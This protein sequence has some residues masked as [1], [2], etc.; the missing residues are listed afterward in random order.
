[1]SAP[2]VEEC[3]T[4]MDTSKSAARG[5][6][7]KI[8]RVTKIF[9]QSYLAPLEQHVKSCEALETMI[10]ANI[11]AICTAWVFDGRYDNQVL[12]NVM[13]SRRSLLESQ[14]EAS[15]ASSGLQG[16]LAKMQI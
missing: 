12:I 16:L 15:S 10:I 11:L 4:I 14:C 13:T 1:L 3:L 5:T 7:E 6:E 9:I 8:E 2:Q